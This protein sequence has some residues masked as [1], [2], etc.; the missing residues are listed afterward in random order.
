MSA[1][2]AGDGA[3]DD[4]PLQGGVHVGEGDELRVRAHA[5]KQV[6]QHR[7]VTA[8]LEALQVFQAGDLGFGEDVVVRRHHVSDL[9]AAVLGGY[10]SHLGLDRVNDVQLVLLGGEEAPQVAHVHDGEV[11]AHVARVNLGRVQRAVLDEAQRVRTGDAQLGEGRNLKDHLPVGPALHAFHEADVFG[12]GIVADG[13]A[14]VHQ[15]AVDAGHLELELLT[16][17][18]QRGLVEVDPALDAAGPARG[19]AASVVVRHGGRRLAITLGGGHGFLLAGGRVHDADADLADAAVIAAVDLVFH[20]HGFGFAGGAVRVDDHADDGTDLIVEDLNTLGVCATGALNPVGNDRVQGCLAHPGLHVVWEVGVFHTL[21]DVQ[22]DAV[23]VPLRLQEAEVFGLV[24]LADLLEDGLVCRTEDSPFLTVDGDVGHADGAHNGPVQVIS[25]LVPALTVARRAAGDAR[26]QDASLQRGVHVG[27]G[28]ELTLGAQAGQQV[29][30]D[31][32]VLPDVLVLVGPKVGQRLTA[33][34][35]LVGVVR[36][37]DGLAAGG[38]PQDADHVVL[39]GVGER[40][41]GVV[42]GGKAPQIADVDD[43]QVSADI[44]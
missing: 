11:A 34:D 1:G 32:A 39:D 27:E 14:A 36:A 25:D 28:H 20:H 33:E 41:V 43:R 24:L 13:Q 19:A 38:I 18:S 2:A 22:V 40:Q 5:G 15:G 9:H 6:A 26:V 30:Q 44:A 8:D 42:A 29:A 10:L 3:V 7:A 16:G 12:L 23:R 4:A 37:E 35:V 21:F 17:G 31:G